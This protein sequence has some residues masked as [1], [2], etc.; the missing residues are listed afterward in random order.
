MP[1]IPR[2][3]R[4]RC[5]KIRNYSLSLRERELFSAAPRHRSPT[6]RA[7]PCGRGRLHERQHYL[8][9]DVARAGFPRTRAAPPLTENLFALHF[10]MFHCRAGAKCADQPAR[11]AASYGF[12]ERGSRTLGDSFVFQPRDLI[13]PPLSPGNRSDGDLGKYGRD[14]DD[15][16]NDAV[17]KR[18][19]STVLFGPRTSSL[20]PGTAG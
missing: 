20:L 4:L 16:D 9:A 18:P 15:D 14:Y 2:L 7:C 1:S 5:V 10:I 13:L 19:R 6:P 17:Y 3:A 8:T 12:R 11:R